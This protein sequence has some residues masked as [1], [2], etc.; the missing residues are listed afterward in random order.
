[1]V[2]FIHEE[3][4][5]KEEVALW[6]KK[7]TAEEFNLLVASR[8]AARS[9]TPTAEQAVPVNLLSVNIPVQ[10]QVTNVLAWASR[11]RDA[12]RLLEHLANREV[13]RYLL[14]MDLE[15]VMTTGRLRAAQAIRDRIQTRADAMGLGAR[16]LLVGLEDIHPP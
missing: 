15:D 14:S 4:P 12:A 11:H 16:V 10:Y 9:A 6:T 8:E 5:G 13:V 1:E 7:H 2:G 3:K